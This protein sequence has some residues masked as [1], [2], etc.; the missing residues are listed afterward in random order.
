MSELIHHYTDINTFSLILNYKTIRFNRLDRVDDIT[1]EESFKVLKLAKFFFVSCW[2]Y[3]QNE[4][5]PQWNMYTKDMAGVRISFPK[6]FFNYLP[7]KVP[8]K[9]KAEQNGQII[10]VIPF[11]K[12]FTDSYMIL[13]NFFDEK[14]FARK[15]EYYEDYEKRKNDSINI[16]ID[17]KGSFNGQIHD[18]TGIAAMKSPDWQFQKEFRF[19]LF[20]F[21]SIPLPP[22]GPFSKEF[23][24]KMPDF[25]AQKL[26]R[27]EGPAIEYFDVD[28]N[29]EVLDHIIV[30]TGPLCTNGDYLIVESLLEKYTKRGT[31]K[32][33]K[34]EGTI[35]KPKR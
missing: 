13:P 15:V 23:S 6:K 26:Y 11:E 7:L 31:I 18:P 24:S 2:T 9:Y 29:P 4:S 19:V 28:I 14:H 35:R 32:K 5:I 12:M 25:I 8:S 21:P 17:S 27:G 20:I 30:T 3:D 34:F 33:S 1:E 22:N 16:E 10:S